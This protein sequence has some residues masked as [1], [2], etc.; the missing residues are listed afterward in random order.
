MWYLL[1]DKDG[2]K[3]VAK[4]WWARLWLE[5][6]Y[7]IDRVRAIKWSDVDDSLDFDEVVDM[8]KLTWIDWYNE[9]LAP[10]GAVA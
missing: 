7:S 1:T 2:Y 4:S 3:F 5:N 6:N 8:A 10:F 9:N